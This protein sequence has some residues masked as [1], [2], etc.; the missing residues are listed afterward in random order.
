[1]GGKCLTHMAMGGAE[2]PAITQEIKTGQDQV[3]CFTFY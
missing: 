2:R 3:S 1:M